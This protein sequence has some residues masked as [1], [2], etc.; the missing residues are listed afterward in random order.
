MDFSHLIIGHK[1]G[2]ASREMPLA[3]YLRH[4]F[5]ENS[6]LFYVAYDLRNDM[7]LANLTQNIYFEISLLQV[8]ENYSRDVSLELVYS[9]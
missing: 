8:D 9:H 6:L 2:T 1:Y 5:G 7:E 3:I 4:N